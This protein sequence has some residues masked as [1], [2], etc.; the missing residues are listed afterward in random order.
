MTESFSKP[1]CLRWYWND[2]HILLLL[3]ALLS[4]LTL[5]PFS[6]VKILY[7]STGDPQSGVHTKY[8]GN[9][10]QV[11]RECRRGGFINSKITLILLLSSESMVH[12]H[13][14]A[15]VHA[16]AKLLP[17]YLSLPLNPNKDARRSC[18]VS[19]NPTP[20]VTSSSTTQDATPAFPLH[21]NSAFPH[22]TAPSQSMP[23]KIDTTSS[24]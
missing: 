2:S 18:R 17:T 11:T 16:A 20:S 14:N 6:K 3:S 24:H 13:L 19:S 7:C 12:L 9:S 1:F 15:R 21:V 5:S 8:G 10:T 23:H 22:L 4:P